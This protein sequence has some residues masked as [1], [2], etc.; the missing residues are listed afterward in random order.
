M[1]SAFDH[2]CAS[3]DKR[4]LLN[5]LDE[6]PTLKTLKCTSTTS[7]FHSHN[8]FATFKWFRIVTV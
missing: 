6:I 7:H 1:V 4:F 3:E 2:V 5:V 8:D